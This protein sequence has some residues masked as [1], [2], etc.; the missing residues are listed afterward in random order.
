MDTAAATL[1]QAAPEQVEAPP[2]PSG[3]RLGSRWLNHVKA[4][5]GLPWQRR[6]ARA[7]LMVP[8]IRRWE[9]DY[10]R[11]ADD[12][13]KQRSMQLRGRARGGESLDKL[14]PE[15]F[16]LACVAIYRRL[17]LR[18]FDVQ[19]AAGVVLHQGGL[20]ELATGEGKTLTA[21]LPVYLNALVGKGVHVATVN[22]Y[23]ARRDAEQWASPVLSLLGLTVGAL[24]QQMGEQ[25]RGKAYR[26][27]V[28]Y[29]TASEFGFDF[30]RDRLKVA[31]A[32]GAEA[33]FWAPWA[34]GNGQY[35]RPLDPKVQREHHF[36][37]VDEA[38]NIFIDEGRTPLIISNPTRPATP[39]EQV[40]YHWANRV[41]QA[42]ERDRH[43]LLDE[44]KQK[45]ELTDEGRQVVRWS[46]PPCG[47]HSHAMDKLFEHVER[48]LHAHFRFR[49][50]QHYLIEKGKVVIIDEFTGRRMPDRHWR[51]GL[52]QAVEAKEA[53]QITMA[54]DHA[55]Q[56][57][58][59]SYFRLYKKL[60]GMTGTAAQNWW[61]IRRV[62]KVWVV[63]VPTN[64]PVIREQWPDRVFPTEGAKFDAVVEEVLRLRAQ[65]RPVLIGTRSVE[66]SEKLSERLA[67]AGVEHQVLNA[68]FHEQEAQV[69]ALA[70]LPGRVTIA[71]NMAGRGTDIKLGPGVAAAGG[72]HI[73]GTERHEARRIDRQLAGR[74][75]RQGDPGSAQFF[76]SLED[77]LLEGL[78]EAKQHRLQEVGRRGGNRD[79]QGYAPIFLKAQRRTERRHY[80]QRVDLLVY[81]KQRQEILKDLGADPYVD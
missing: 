79:W 38:D 75:G 29:G 24:Q 16:G 21:L 71:T 3:N 60:A 46:N 55:A 19:L 1:G 70:G 51:E 23:L 31:G 33:P 45:I 74:A 26:C 22:D 69:V 39:E 42:L 17:Q 11:L 66:K 48:G 41:A 18:P 2:P 28:T 52:H 47:P 13:L 56:I 49:R 80:R 78:G 54:A 7:A 40:V 30:L 32:R 68:K 20:A 58:F 8:A 35:Q 50:D 59:Q 5:I 10:S 27:D 81:E 57:T 14:L 63:C 65:G 36:A 6:L 53:V 43:F 67:R 72:L 61:E 64:R 44:K 25:D 76:L 15:A 77:E 34:R 4:L 9:Q 73:L 12:A 62:Y 37:L